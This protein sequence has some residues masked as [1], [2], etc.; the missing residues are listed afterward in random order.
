MLRLLPLL[1]LLTGC[2]T[3]RHVE[4]DAE[5]SAEVSRDQVCTDWCEHMIGCGVLA[6][7]VDYCVSAC[8]ETYLEESCAPGQ[9]EFLACISQAPCDAVAASG[10]DGVCSEEWHRSC[11][12]LYQGN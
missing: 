11:G 5:T 4:G 8:L 2:N 3:D 1:V 7:D 6:P 10:P 12:P 9:T